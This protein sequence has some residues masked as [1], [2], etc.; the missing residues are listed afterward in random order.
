MEILAIPAKKEKPAISTNCRLYQLFPRFRETL[1]C[2]VAE[3]EG[4]EP[5]DLL[6]SIVFKTIAIDHS[7][8]SPEYRPYRRFQWCKYIKILDSDKIFFSK[9]S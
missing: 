9:N 3:R 5:P 7:A 2:I 1:Y 4:F 8:I 6:Q